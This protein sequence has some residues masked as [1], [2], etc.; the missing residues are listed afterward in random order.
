ML[1]QGQSNIQNV[2][3]TLLGLELLLGCIL[4]ICEAD[5]DFILTQLI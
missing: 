3:F 5:E 2:L 1:L 4:S